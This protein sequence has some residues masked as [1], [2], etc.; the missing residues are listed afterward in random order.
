MSQDYLLQAVEFYTG[1]D[2]IVPNVDY[3][4][5]DD[6]EGVYLKEWKIPN[7]T[8][9]TIEQLLNIASQV[10]G[11]YQFLEIKEKAIE[12][13]LKAQAK[14]VFFLNKYYLDCS[15]GTTDLLIKARLM[16]E[17]TN[18]TE[19]EIIDY[20]GVPTTM[21][22]ADINLILGDKDT[23]IVGV[24]SLRRKDLHTQMIEILKKVLLGLPYEI[25]YI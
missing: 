6:G 1:R 22:L 8:Q 3:C 15:D 11:A 7:T 24:L 21:T 16:L 20:Q 13:Q 5:Q 17:G 2:D 9:P 25:V 14:P 19:V 4:I 10:A 18:T 23:S 12:E